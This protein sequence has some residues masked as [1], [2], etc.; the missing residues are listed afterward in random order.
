MRSSGASC[1]RIV[2]VG[3][4][5]GFLVGLG[6]AWEGGFGVA[7]SPACVGSGVSSAVS[8]G[9]AV[10]GSLVGVGD[11]VGVGVGSGD[12][13]LFWTTVCDSSGAPASIKAVIVP[14]S[15]TGRVDA[16][17]IVMSGA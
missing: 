4:G 10:L 7:R 16:S 6:V 3:S 1:R 9:S 12:G 8:V 15:A 11:G 13:E 14:Q 5:V 2:G 17:L